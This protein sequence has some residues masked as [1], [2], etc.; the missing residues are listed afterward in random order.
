MADDAMTDVCCSGR[1]L[2]YEELTNRCGS[3]EEALRLARE[4]NMAESQR[5]IHLTN[6]NEHLM[7]QLA[8][9]ADTNQMLTGIIERLTRAGRWDS[10]NEAS[11][12]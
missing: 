8:R 11:N 5:N 10:C 7:R 9:L 12:G 1:E 3:L 2:T 6:D 4:K